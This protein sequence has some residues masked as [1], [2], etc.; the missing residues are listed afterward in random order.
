MVNMTFSVK[1]NKAIRKENYFTGA[2]HVV[3]TIQCFF[4]FLIKETNHFKAPKSI[5]ILYVVK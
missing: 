3:D 1:Q 4:N 2:D 5:I